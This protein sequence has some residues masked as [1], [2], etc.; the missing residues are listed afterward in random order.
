MAKGILDGDAS[1]K[2]QSLR[3]PRVITAIAMVLTPMLT[4]YLI[5]H[6]MHGR[7]VPLWV[8]PLFPPAFAVMI[9]YIMPLLV[10]ISYE[11]DFP[12][13]VPL[14]PSHYYTLFR[15]TMYALSQNNFK[16]KAKDV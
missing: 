16:I 15:K 11:E 14:N 10:Y 2:L 12:Q 1:F 8:F 9:A 5:L 6:N 7:A 13:L 3:K 4:G